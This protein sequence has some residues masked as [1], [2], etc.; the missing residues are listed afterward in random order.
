MKPMR[1][2]VIHVGQ[3]TNDFNPVPTTLRDYESFGIVEGAPILQTPSGAWARSAAS[4]TPSSAPD[5]TS[6]SCPSCAAGPWRGR[7]TQDA[8]RFFERKIIRR[9]EGRRSGS[10]ASRCSC[11][12][13]ARPTAST[14]WRARSWPPAAPC[15]GRTFPSCS[16][17]DHHANI[18]RQM[19]SLATAI[20]GHRTQPHDPLRHRPHGA[21]R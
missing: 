11:M 10:T 9:P 21:P 6:R 19:V 5:A 12:A 17:L 14:M 1:I 15:S 8:Y 7:I 3:E 13:P 18:T 4:S 20:V 16:G 2:A